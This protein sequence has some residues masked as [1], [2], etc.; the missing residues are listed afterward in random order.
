MF[1]G[2]RNRCCI[3]IDTAPVFLYLNISE[4]SASG[5][6]LMAHDAEELLSLL[7]DVEIY[8][9][10]FE[11]GVVSVVLHAVVMA[12]ADYGQFVFHGVGIYEHLLVSLELAALKHLLRAEHKL[13]YLLADWRQFFYIGL[14]QRV[15]V[16]IYMFLDRFKHTLETVDELL[17]AVYTKVVPGVALYGN[18]N[19]H[20]T[21]G[22]EFL[23]AELLE[24]LLLVLQFAMA[25]VEGAHALSC[26]TVEN[27]VILVEGKAVD[28]AL[29]A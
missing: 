13:L 20:A 19:G 9:G 4:E 14:R 18:G 11:V 12:L 29:C 26:K 1:G 17:V 2:K 22:K 27:L 24:L 5:T 23:A 28:K 7:D 6:Q 25:V 8:E 15:E 3:A 16:V 10:D 21:E